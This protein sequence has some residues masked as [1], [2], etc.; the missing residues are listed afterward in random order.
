M[1]LRSNDY[2]V[3][4]ATSPEDAAMVLA[5]ATNPA[6]ETYIAFITHTPEGPTVDMSIPVMMNV[7][8]RAHFYQRV[9]TMAA[10]ARKA[11]SRVT[12]VVVRKVDDTSPLRSS[13]EAGDYFP[14]VADFNEAVGYVRLRTQTSRAIQ[15][16]GNRDT[17]AE[18]YGVHVSFATLE[19]VEKASKLAE[20]L[21]KA[22]GR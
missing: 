15:K 19:E 7:T 3:V 22:N 9:L 10:N 8:D 2:Q 17:T 6:C 5:H 14:S 1:A 12:P 18:F 21:A 16:A 13:V 4:K 20:D 11:S